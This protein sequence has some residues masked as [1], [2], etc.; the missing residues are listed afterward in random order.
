M[1]LIA[2]NRWVVERAA[3]RV[4]GPRFVE[5]AAECPSTYATPRARS[6]RDQVEG[7]RDLGRDRDQAQALEE[8]LD[9]RP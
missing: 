2:L 5:V 6:Q 7:P 3:G 4:A 9:L 8:R 1:P